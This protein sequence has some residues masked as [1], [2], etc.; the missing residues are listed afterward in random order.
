MLLDELS[1]LNVPGSLTARFRKFIKSRKFKRVTFHDLRHT[2]ATHLLGQNIH[3]KVV[4]ERL[5]HS[6][7]AL[8]MNTYSHVM[9]T[10]QEEAADK[11]DDMLSITGHKKGT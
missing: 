10:M 8:T 5:G 7:I 9:P 4:S 1:G 3:P 2:H 6:T 11:V